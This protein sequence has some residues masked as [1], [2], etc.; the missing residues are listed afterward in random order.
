MTQNIQSLINKLSNQSLEK[1]LFEL[2]ENN[3]YETIIHILSFKNLEEQNNKIKQWETKLSYKESK[4][5]QL[6]YSNLN[7]DN[8]HH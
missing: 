1:I 2:D 7:L 4:L 3:K 6:W 8:R 5:I